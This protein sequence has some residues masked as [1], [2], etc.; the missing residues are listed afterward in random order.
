M[1]S[2]LHTR[3]QS[4]SLY[5][6]CLCIPYQSVNTNSGEHKRKTG[7][8]VKPDVF[9]LQMRIRDDPFTQRACQLRSSWGAVTPACT[10]DLLMAVSAGSKPQLDICSRV[11]QS[12]LRPLPNGPKPFTH[13]RVLVKGAFEKQLTFNPISC[14]QSLQVLF[15]I[16]K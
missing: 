6:L 4:S 11:C 5:L 15:Q 8:E 1:T 13:F 2:A 16:N 14:N 9:S 10:Y 3:N 7:K 12:L